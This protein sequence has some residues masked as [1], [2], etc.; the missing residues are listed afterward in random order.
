M[1]E[2]Y[3]QLS[4]MFFGLLIALFI[5]FADKTLSTAIMGLVVFVSVII[6]DAIS[7][8]IKI[9]LFSYIIKRLEREVNVPGKGTI[10]FFIST[11][12]CLLFFE[13]SDVFLGILVLALLD[14]FSTII[15]IK[16]GRT[17]IYKEK[18]LEGT[19]AGIIASFIALV[20]FT[21]PVTALIASTGAGIAELI[22][23]VD[24]NLVIP[25]VVCIILSI[26]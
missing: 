14:S 21:G 5:Y 22:S 11:L 18:S 1:K 4:H 12:F 19:I 23:P 24:D 6:S 10:V 20:Y 7:K 8:G 13:K 26:I 15:G 25:V 3:R 16:F 17:K 2:V 9:P